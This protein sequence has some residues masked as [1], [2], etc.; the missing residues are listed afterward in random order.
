MRHRIGVVVGILVIGCSAT[1]VADSGARRFGVMAGAGVPD[2]TSASAVYRP[3]SAVRL[4]AG[5]AYNFIGMGVSGG[6]TVVPF[7]TWFT[8]TLS[9]D[10]GRYFEG[11]ANPLA[12]MVSGDP[13]FSS[14]MLEKVGY[15]YANAHLGLEFGREWATFF[16]HAG[17]SRVA[18]AVNGFALEATAAG[19]GEVTFTEDPTV[20]LWTVSARLGLIVYLVQ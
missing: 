5:M 14:T 9:L 20:A 2:G 11:D 15:D 3:L 12:Q 18:G 19:D 16:I 6:L 1:A 4:N 8:P 7:K 17:M 10:A 13:T